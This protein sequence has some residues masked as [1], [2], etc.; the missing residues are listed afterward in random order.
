MKTKISSL[1]S[2]GYNDIINKYTLNSNTSNIRSYKR[3]ELNNNTAY[4][5]LEEINLLKDN[6]N[7]IPHSIDNSY[8]SNTS[9]PVADNSSYETVN[10][11]K[12]ENLELKE[13]VMMTINEY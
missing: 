7:S 3:I 2:L 8:V 6:S 11:F 4:M 13:K 12:T 1:T 10:Y 9:T 5:N